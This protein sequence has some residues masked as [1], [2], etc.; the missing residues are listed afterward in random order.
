MIIT[1]QWLLDH[2]TNSG[3]YTKAQID[4]LKIPYP[5]RKGWKQQVKGMEIT[6]SQRKRFEQG[7]HTKSGGPLDKLKRMF[8]R[9]NESEQDNF[10]TWLNEK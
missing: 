4:A 1:N 2:R 5:P 9:L 6:E 7:K 8:G 3:G 10:K